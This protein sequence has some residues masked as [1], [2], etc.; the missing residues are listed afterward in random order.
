MGRLGAVRAIPHLLAA[1][2]DDA[3]RVARSVGR[4]LRLLGDTLAVQVMT[5]RLVSPGATAHERQKAVVVLGELRD[6]TA[7]KALIQALEDPDHTLRAVT[8][9]ALGQIGDIEAF[10]P[11]TIQSERRGASGS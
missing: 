9:H 5:D 4:S 10:Q 7:V 3:T 1:L 6:R 2:D 11:L 8:A